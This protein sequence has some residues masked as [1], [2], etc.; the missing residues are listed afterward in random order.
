M[1]AA[2]GQLAARHG[3]ERRGGAKG[4]SWCPFTK[5]AVSNGK[6]LQC[7]EQPGSR[8]CV[9]PRVAR[10]TRHKVQLLGGKGIREQV[11]RNTWNQ[12]TR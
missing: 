9:S 10:K 11:H 4:E 6:D 8:R 3:C 7:S 1:E 12:V 2:M 5:Q